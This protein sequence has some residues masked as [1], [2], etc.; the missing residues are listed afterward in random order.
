[1][2][3]KKDEYFFYPS[4]KCLKGT[5]TLMI[6]ILYQRKLYEPGILTQV[7]SKSVEK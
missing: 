2:S 3:I 1:M 4:N 7:S 5:A 6:S